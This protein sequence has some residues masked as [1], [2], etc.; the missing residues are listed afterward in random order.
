M[1]KA[2][3]GTGGGLDPG[4]GLPPGIIFLITHLP[5]ILLV[6][7]VTILFPGIIAAPWETHVV[8]YGIPR[9]ELRTQ[10][11]TIGQILLGIRK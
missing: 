7:P 3:R 2:G 5:L 1:E 11:M 6:E 9:E 4:S 10:W 8:W